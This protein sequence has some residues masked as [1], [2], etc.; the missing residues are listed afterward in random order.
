MADIILVDLATVDLLI[1]NGLD[2]GL[3]SLDGC[4]A[5]VSISPEMKATIL[6]IY[7]RRIDSIIGPTELGAAPLTIK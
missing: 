3:H 1:K 7:A 5:K 2:A 4:V 6:A